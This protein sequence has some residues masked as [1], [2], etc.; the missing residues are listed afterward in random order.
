MLERW[1]TPECL[2]SYEVLVE[3]TVS[4]RRES[5]LLDLACGDG[6]LLGLL[7]R[8]GFSDLVGVDW[9]PE[10]LAGARERLGPGAELHCQDAC[11]LTLPDGSVDMA[12]SHLALMLM[13]PVE[14]VLAEIARV[15]KPGG[16]LVAVVNR[17]VQ[18][19]VNEVYRRWLHRT[20]A[21]L[22]LDRLRLGDPRAFAVEGLREL[23]RGQHFDSE[24]LLIRDFEVR[25]NAT[26]SALW[27]SLRLSYD[28]FQL[29]ESAQ[30]ALERGILRDWE[31]LRDEDG[32]LTCAMGMRF[33]K[34][35]TPPS[36]R[37]P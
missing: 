35:R 30:A 4:L 36:C 5:R 13:A 27:S 28:V 15:V 6:Y 2:S 26:P 32:L 19:P 10:E 25:A 18:D 17:Y 14:P 12:M 16:C 34:C 23:L 20:T 1:R 33:V 22:G 3:E 31:P 29:P 24:S 8:R 37:Q 7:S 21:E 9:S 11:A